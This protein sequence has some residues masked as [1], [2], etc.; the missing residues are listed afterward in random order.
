MTA[1]AHKVRPKKP[2]PMTC[3]APLLV[4]AVALELVE[5]VLELAPVEAEEA[6]VV[7]EPMLMPMLM[8][9]LEDTL[10]TVD[11]PTKV[12]V[13]NDVDAVAELDA[14]VVEVDMADDDEAM[15]A[16]TLNWGD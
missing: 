15:A 4:L 7:V 1:A 2:P 8:G 14:A 16:S 13:D 9:M 5:D 10:V 6:I 3:D 12:T 11:P